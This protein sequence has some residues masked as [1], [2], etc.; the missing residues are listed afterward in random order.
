MKTGSGLQ[1]EQPR[2]LTDASSDDESTAEQHPR[3]DGDSHKHGTDGEHEA[4]H[5]YDGLAAKS[6]RRHPGEDREGP[7]AR[8]GHRHHQFLPQVAQLKVGPKLQHRARYD[9]RV[10]A[11]EEASDGRQKSRANQQAGHRSFPVAAR[12]G[13]DA[14]SL[15]VALK[16]V[17]VVLRWPR[18]LGCGASFPPGLG[19]R[20]KVKKTSYKTQ[21]GDS[22]VLTVCPSCPDGLTDRL[23]TACNQ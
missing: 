15:V 10:I 9:A 16:S 21:L 7:S 22:T 23:A 18:Q 13:N 17:H 19:G 14:L 12:V 3:V 20:I 5:Q 2:K 4:G 11:E 1:T 8:D 6:V